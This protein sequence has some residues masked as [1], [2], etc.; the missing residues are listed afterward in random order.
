MAKC[1]IEMQKDW[2]ATLSRCGKKMYLPLLKL[3][4]QLLLKI[5]YI[6]TSGRSSRDI[7]HPQL[8]IFVP[9]TAMKMS[10]NCNKYDRISQNIATYRGGKMELRISSV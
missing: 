4:I 1:N 3:P 5:D 6:K 8:A 9:F 10:E 2:Q 7:L